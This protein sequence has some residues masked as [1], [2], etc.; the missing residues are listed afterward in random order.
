MG[1]IINREWSQHLDSTS[2]A[3]NSICE[4]STDSAVNQSRVK[5]PPSSL[6][7]TKREKSNNSENYSRT[8]SSCNSTPVINKLAMSEFDPRSPSSQIVRT[9]IYISGEVDANAKS[10]R[11][12]L[13][14]N[15]SKQQRA[16][17]VKS[18]SLYLWFKLVI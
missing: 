4:A 18:R 16:A 8:N 9:P 12:L 14:N 1:N 7:A 17:L 2:S 15:N 11:P 10:S 13:A 3:E 6:N 5:A